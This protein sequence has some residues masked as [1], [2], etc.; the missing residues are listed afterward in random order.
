MTD[1]LREWLEGKLAKT[2]VYKRYKLFKVPKDLKVSIENRSL[3]EL[4]ASFAFRVRLCW[5]AGKLG[6][7]IRG[8]SQGTFKGPDELL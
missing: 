6:F 2:F 1:S 5:R 4:A 3:G 8:G 7:E